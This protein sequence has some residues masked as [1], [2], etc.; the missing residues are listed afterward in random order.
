MSVSVNQN[1]SKGDPVG[2]LNGMQVPWGT[3]VQ[4]GRFPFLPLYPLL[5]SESQMRRPSFFPLI[6]CLPLCLIELLY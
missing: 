6:H 4:K 5:E 2:S 3:L 1:G